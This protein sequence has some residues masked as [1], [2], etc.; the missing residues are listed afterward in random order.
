MN[1]T[2]TTETADWAVTTPGLVENMPDTVYHGDPVVSGP[3]LSS[4]FA[5]LLTSH[6]PAKALALKHREPTPA[7]QLGTIVHRIVLGEETPD[8][9]SVDGLTVIPGDGRT[10][11]VKDARAEAIAAG[12]NVVSET[13]YEARA[14]MHQKL[15]AM[16]EAVQ[17]HPVIGPLVEGK[18]EVSAFWQDD[19]T[20]VWLRARFDIL[21]DG[22]PT[23]YKTTVDASRRGFQKAVGRFGYHQQADFYCRALRALGINSNPRFRFI[24]Q[25]TTAPYLVNLHECDDVAMEVARDLNDRAIRLFA[26]CVKAAEWPGYAID[27][28]PVSLPAWYFFEHEEVLPDTWRP[29]ENE[30]VI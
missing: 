19:A 21:A 29:L 14:D 30:I 17:N 12:L 24:A 26:Q 15:T 20:G 11:A 18:H 13:E 4:T 3:S 28:E 1:V 7:M 9:Y 6:V 23:D 27:P 2:T 5:R 25:E 10:K 16:L 8:A 22:E